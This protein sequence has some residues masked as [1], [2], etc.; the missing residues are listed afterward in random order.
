MEVAASMSISIVKD[1]RLWGLVACHHATPRALPYEVRAALEHLGE[2]VALQLTARE[3][4]EG[5]EY[6][7]ALKAI[8]TQLLAQMAAHD[9]FVDAL[10]RN[11]DLLLRLTRSSG[12]AISMDGVVHLVG[13]TPAQ[14]DVQR[15][16]DWLPHQ[17][18]EWGERLE[19]K[20]FH[21]DGLSAVFPAAASMIQSA[22]GI[23][24]V[25]IPRFRKSHIVWFRPEMVR[26]VKWAGNP[27]KPVEA[28]ERMSP[29]KSFETWKD[30]VRAK[31]LPWKKEEIQ[32][33]NELRESIVAIILRKAEELA[34]LNSELTRSNK[35]LESFS[36]SVSHDL[37]APFRHIFGFSQLLQK[38]ASGS[39]DDTSK[40]YINTIMESAKFAGTLVDNLLAFSQMGRT[41]LKLR[42]VDMSVLVDEVLKDLKS[43]NASRSIQWQIDKLPVV[44]GDL[45]MLKLAVYNL[46]SNAVKY[47]R[48]RDPAVIEMGTRV[49]GTEYIFWVRDNGV[50]FD[51]RFKDKLFGVFQR[52]HRPDEFE[53]TGIGLANVSRT[54]ERHA[55]RTWAEGQLGIGATFYFSLPVNKSEA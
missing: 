17:E 47:T 39:L 53:G 34:A 12:C 27:N 1:G 20:A 29:R 11:P 50:G 46:L 32:A 45:V 35:E 49:E 40:R 21:T 14:A 38:R 41:P 26:T 4:A 9:N 6:R 23:L 15:L 36:Y 10:V 24:A 16:M 54:I 8:Q 37:R 18:Q 51:M 25:S 7:I 48:G 19:Q 28:G 55:G 42:D 13:D 44:H 5:A 3:Y 22:S 33:A 2:I 31:S 30:T 52:L 43:E